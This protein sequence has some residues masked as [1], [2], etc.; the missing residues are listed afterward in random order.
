VLWELR[1]DQGSWT[2]RMPGTAVI[3]DVIE[4]EPMR[5]QRRVS[6]GFRAVNKLTPQNTKRTGISTVGSGATFGA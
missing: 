4:G 5:P 3:A 1:S 2:C 6:L